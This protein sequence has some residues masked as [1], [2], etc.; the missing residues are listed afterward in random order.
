[1]KTIN[2]IKFILPV[3]LSVLFLSV[4]A[5]SANPRKMEV[6]IKSTVECAMCKKN[7]ETK[8]GKIKGIR[9]VTADYAA[10]EITVVYNS[11]KI[12]LD[13]IKKA[14]AEIGYDAD[15][16]PANNKLTKLLKHKEKEAEKK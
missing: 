4:N 12:S 16:V 9:K 1:M 6:K 11:K 10:K 15:E 3:I 2:K 14:I 7:L 13:E 8:L 5:Q